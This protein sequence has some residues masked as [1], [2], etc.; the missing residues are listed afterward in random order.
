VTSVTDARTAQPAIG[1]EP[2]PDRPRHRRRWVLASALGAVLIAGGAAAW[3]WAANAR[4]EVPPSMAGPVATAVIER[5]AISATEVWDG[6]LGYGAPFTVTAGTEGVVT[7][8]ADQDEAVRRGSELFR[9]NEQPVILLYGAVPMYRDLGPGDSGVDVRQLEANLV[10]LGYSGF[11]ADNEYA[12][13]TSE[14]VREWQGD[15]GTAETGSV[16]RATVVFAPGGRRVDA[17]HVDVG[18]PVVPGVPVLDV[19]GVDKVVSVDVEVDDRDL[20]DVGT[21]VTVVLPEG[22]EVPGRISE[23][24]VIEVPSEGG[25]A[26]ETGAT[27]SESIARIEITLDERVSDDVVG[28][29]VDVVVAIDKRTDVLLVP[30]NALL[31]LAEGGYGLEIL[32]DDGTTKIVAVDTGLFGDG[33]VQVEGDGIAEGTVVGV[34][35]R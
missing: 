26:F 28:A 17:L 29:A 18:D 7:R 15:I 27:E 9:I 35:G 24:T 3:L 16:A 12:D 30:V 19:T 6:T 8:L 31:A 33:K 5:G 20:F 4:T 22:N 13:D 34:A 14:V 25:G 10:R 32:N 11:V 1:V 21:A 23:T 2:E